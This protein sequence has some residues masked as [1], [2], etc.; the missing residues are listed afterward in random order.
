METWWWW[1]MQLNWV[2]T[3]LL[4]VLKTKFWL[5]TNGSTEQLFQGDVGYAFSDSSA[6][7]S[8]ALEGGPIILLPNLPSNQ[9]QEYVT[10]LLSEKCL[11][12]F[13]TVFQVVLL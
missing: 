12:W 4:G 3:F 5:F 13:Q 10:V 6:F 1:G 7:A 9:H 8:F 2:E 11:R